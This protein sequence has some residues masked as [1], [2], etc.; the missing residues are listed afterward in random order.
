MS[1]ILIADDEKDLVE[2]LVMIMNALGHEVFGAS[3]GQKAI[4][5]VKKEKPQ[6]IFLD[7]CFPAPSLDGVQILKAIRE[8]DKN[9]KVVLTSGLSSEDEKCKEVQKLGVTKF[10]AKP[11]NVAKI[12]EII[13]ELIK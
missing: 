1:K 11:I 10:L 5:I 2:S 9:V 6:I 13:R 7:L 4:D 8:F 12:Q 3:D